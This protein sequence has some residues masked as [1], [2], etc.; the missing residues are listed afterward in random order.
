MSTKTDPLA[1]ALDAMTTGTALGARSKIDVYFGDRP[2]VIDAI[3]RARVERK[4]SFKQ[5]A[6]KL[7]EDPNV[8]LTEGSVSAWLNKRGIT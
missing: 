1:E 2:Q 8:S 3:I 6:L 5:I 4:L 7:S